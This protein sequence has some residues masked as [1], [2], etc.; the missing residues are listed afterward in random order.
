MKRVV[1][2]LFG[3]RDPKQ[4]EDYTNVILTKD[5]YNKDVVDKIESL[6]N[7][8]NH[9]KQEHKNEIK[10][11]ETAANKKIND[12]KAQA[13][14]RV[15]EANAETDKHESRADS[16]E[17]MNQNLIRILTERANAKRGLIPKKEHI[18]YLFLTAEDY[19][20]TFKCG[21]SGSS[22]RTTTVQCSC[23][24]IRLQSPYE[25]SVDF[26]AVTGLIYNDLLKKFGKNIGIQKVYANDYF[27]NWEDEPIRSLWKYGR[28]DEE[29][30]KRK[31][32]NFV[33]KTSCKAN[34][35]KGFWE[36]EYLTRSAV[37]I[38]PEMID[39]T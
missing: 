37:K 14:K 2:S 8:I 23:F 9:L 7:Q 11:N 16:F 35:S 15:A 25:I 21:V 6:Q 26:Q 13:D 28:L 36:V 1:N 34:I 27:Q 30:G 22:R 32:E 24:R 18:G 5:E 38:L 39:K 33:F 31:Y 4:N 3:Y 10:D 12:A 29:T 17:S 19:T 20:F